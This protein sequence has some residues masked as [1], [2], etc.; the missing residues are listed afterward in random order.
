[1]A[2]RYRGRF[3]PTPSGP[4]HFGSL[5][6]AL[7]SYLDALSQ[8][9]AWL[10]RIEDVDAPRVVPGAADAILR[11]L[12]AHGFEWHGAVM[13]QS[14]R[15][16]AYRATLDDLRRLGLVYACGCSRKALAESARRGIDG[17]VYPGT[18]RARRLADAGHALRFRVPATRIVFMDRQQGA[19]ACDIARECGD[20]V[21]RRADGVY[22]Y[23]LAAVVDDAEQGISDI[24]RGADLLASTPRHIALQAALGLATPTYRHLPVVLDGRGD[25]LSKQ[26]LATAI[27]NT[28]PLAGLR[29]A[30]AFL[31][32]ATR[33][34]PDDLAGFWIWAR[35]AWRS[36]PGQALRGKRWPPSNPCKP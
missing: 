23:H 8:D 15:A 13:W 4:L 36:A 35:T 31:G 32:L 29:A 19:V 12:E 25:K 33:E 24:V 14:R 17:P 5:V 18:C 34:S 7:G 3:A 30:G 1:V 16:E 21:A 22:A 28:R 27:D 2:P 20:F 26:T 10:L 6:A 9:G 11:A